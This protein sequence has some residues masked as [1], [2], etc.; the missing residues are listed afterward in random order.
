M[1]KEQDR[2]V[3]VAEAPAQ[4]LDAGGTVVHVYAG[5]KVDDILNE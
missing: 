2:I 1:I 3:P 5:G 4:G